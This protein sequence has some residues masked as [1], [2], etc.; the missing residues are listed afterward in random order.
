M[1]RDKVNANY[2]DFG[3]DDELQRLEELTNRMNRR[4]QLIRDDAIEAERI[5]KRLIRRMRRA[6][7]Q[8]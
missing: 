3:K 2:T 6:R 7:G 8:E 5:R 4:K 1:H